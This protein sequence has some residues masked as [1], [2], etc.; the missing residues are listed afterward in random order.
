MP[1]QAISSL[2]FTKFF[3]KDMVSD[4]LPLL[5]R[6][7]NSINNEFPSED[8]NFGIC[9]THTQ[10]FGG[11]YCHNCILSGC[12]MMLSSPTMSGSSKRELFLE[13]EETVRQAW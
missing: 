4:F 9:Q 5:F 6:L 1:E 2:V 3:K 7:E 8:A 13:E 11:K 10:G 12:A